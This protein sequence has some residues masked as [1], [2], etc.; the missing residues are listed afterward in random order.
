VVPVEL[1]FKTLLLVLQYITL[2]VA[3]DQPDNT[4]VQMYPGALEV[5]APV[6]PVDLLAQQLMLPLTQAAVV[7]AERIIQSV[8]L[9]ALEMA[10]LVSLLLDHCQQPHL[11]RVRLQ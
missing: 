10:V 7:V 6:F 2:E 11:P 5:V 4:R 8:E 3:V 9:I 1:G